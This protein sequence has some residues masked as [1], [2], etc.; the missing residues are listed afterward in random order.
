[1][2]QLPFGPG[3][4]E[5]ATSNYLADQLEPAPPNVTTEVWQQAKEVARRVTV[6]APLIPMGDGL[7][8]LTSTLE[9]I[10]LEMGF[11]ADEVIEEAHALVC[12]KGYRVELWP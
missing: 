12:E 6:L 11:D 7:V 4:L 5:A 10:A 9:F 8:D 3:P 1:M 2:A